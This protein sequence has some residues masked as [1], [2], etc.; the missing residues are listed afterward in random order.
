MTCF[1]ELG[2]CEDVSIEIGFEGVLGLIPNSF[3]ADKRK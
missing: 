2:G 1:G 3:F